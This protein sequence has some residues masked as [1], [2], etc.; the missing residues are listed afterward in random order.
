MTLE[1]ALGRWLACAV[2]PR[3]AWCSLRA[4]GRAMLI[5]TYFAAGYVGA[6]LVLL[7]G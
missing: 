6:L 2:H 1:R 7:A 4:R 5:A 3:A